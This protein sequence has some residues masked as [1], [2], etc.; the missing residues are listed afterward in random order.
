MHK[1]YPQ[2]SGRDAQGFNEHGEEMRKERLIVL[3]AKWTPKG[4][5][6]AS[7]KVSA[8]QPVVQKRAKL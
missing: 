7:G 8:H 2:V 4:A 3:D 6:C 5:C 1:V